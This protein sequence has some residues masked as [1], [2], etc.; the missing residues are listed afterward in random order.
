[1]P[2]T[3]GTKEMKRV[4][5]MEKC[6]GIRKYHTCWLETRLVCYRHAPYN[7]IVYRYLCVYGHSGI[8]IVG[9]GG[10]VKIWTL[11]VRVRAELRF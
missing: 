4:Q 10:Y 3:C 6:L 2:R 5:S 9:G 7:C 8:L 11:F 1:M